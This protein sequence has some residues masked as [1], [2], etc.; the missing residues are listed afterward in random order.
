MTIVDC[1]VYTNGERRKGDLDLQDAYEHCASDNSSWVWIGL[2]EPTEEEFR[3]VREEFNLHPLAVEDAINAHQRPKLE[4]YGDSLFLV[5]KPARYNEE[6][7]EVIFG[8]IL[9]FVGEG[10]LITVRHGD[11]TELHDVRVESE[12]NPGRMQHGPAAI[13]HAILD[14][15]VDDY[16]PVLAGV[17]DD[18]EEVEEEVFAPDGRSSPA[19]RIY[20]LKREALELHRA[21]APLV[22]PLERL[23]SADHPYVPEKMTSYF[24]DVNDHILRV[25][26]QVEN[27]R[28]ML[29]SVL[30]AN[31]TQVTVRQNEDMRKISAWVAILAVPTM[32]AGIYGMNFDHMPELHWK[33]GYPLAL[34]VM[35]LVCV[36]LWRYF[37]RAGWL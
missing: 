29:N 3:S 1:A 27:F 23:A 20:N 35:V 11:T 10:F 19:A 33:L 13:L 25:N 8:E 18:I 24:R 14:R 36:S 5:L 31:L 28:E 9:I 34:T 21:T 6:K 30:G 15:I 2:H 4:E 26:E 37:K 7:E 22:D 12:R 32:I 17:E 16:Q